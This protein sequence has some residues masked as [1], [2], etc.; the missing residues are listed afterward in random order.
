MKKK[1][2]GQNELNLSSLNK[3]NSN[4]NLQNTISPLSWKAQQFSICIV[5]K[6]LDTIE[7]NIIEAKDNLITHSRENN[8][9]PRTTNWIGQMAISTDEQV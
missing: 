5:I 3:S 7:L 6:C 2:V 9:G 4:Y 1:K 8:F